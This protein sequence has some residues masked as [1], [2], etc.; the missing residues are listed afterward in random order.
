MA[1]KLNDLTLGATSS[2][3]SASDGRGTMSLALAVT[4]TERRQLQEMLSHAGEMEEY[5]SALG[6]SVILDTSPNGDNTVLLTPNSATHVDD[7][8]FVVEDVSD[9]WQNSTTVA[10]VQCALR[11]ICGRDD[12]AVDAAMTAEFLAH[13]F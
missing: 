10:R 9:D 11:R 12:A 13:D 8:W 3:T 7:G 1:W 4:P 6:G 2:V 5:Q